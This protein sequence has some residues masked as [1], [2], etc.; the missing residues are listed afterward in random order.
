MKHIKTNTSI[1][2]NDDIYEPNNE[3]LLRDKS[4]KQMEDLN[5]I[6]KS[7]GG[8]IQDIVK[9][10]E[11]KKE[12]EIPNTVYMD[13]PFDSK[14][15]SIE[16]IEDFMKNDSHNKS[17]SMKSKDQKNIKKLNKKFILKE[18]IDDS[19]RT[20][21]AHFQTYIL[22]NLTDQEQ[23]IIEKIDIIL[24]KYNYDNE[25]NVRLSF[26]SP[27]N[28]EDVY[29]LTLVN[30]TYPIYKDIVEIV[31]KFN[32]VSDYDN[33]NKLYLNIYYKNKKQ[34]TM[35]LNRRINEGSYT[36]FLINYGKTINECIFML[37]KMNK[38]FDK[39]S[40]SEIFDFNNFSKHIKIVM[41]TYDDNVSEMIDH[42]I[43]TSSDIDADDIAKFAIENQNTYGTEPQMILY[44]INDVYG[45]YKS[46][47]KNESLNESKKKDKNYLPYKPLKNLKHFHEIS[48]D[49][50]TTKKSNINDDSWIKGT[51]DDFKRPMFKNLPDTTIRPS[52]DILRTGKIIT[53]FGRECRIIGI[54]NGELT[55]DV[56]GKNNE[57]EIVKY[58][59]ND[60]MRELNKNKK[61]DKKIKKDQ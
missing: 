28:K 29:Q 60:V 44:A 26:R 11:K 33:K 35:N 23:E 46:L 31:E 42:W 53:L 14:R 38:M 52:Y 54:K 2:I 57:H 30:V 8:D 41:K 18:S 47:L 55:V 1:N 49:G 24:F 6:I 45:V 9:K 4:R 43:N 25:T 48:Y 12:N 22:P 61:N 40:D 20:M 51:E 3:S 19:L 15:N 34:N 7:S 50:D 32:I 37:K 17:I 5:K 16:T 13:N 36:D 27:E 10:G 56:M 58:D 59:T 39:V 21:N